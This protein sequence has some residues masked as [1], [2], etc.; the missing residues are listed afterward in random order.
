MDEAGTPIKSFSVIPRQFDKGKPTTELRADRIEATDGKFEIVVNRKEGKYV[1]AIE[2][3]GFRSTLTKAFD[4]TNAKEPI[5]VKLERAPPIQFK[6]VDEKGNAI[7]DAIVIVVPDGQFYS[8]GS[9]ER[10]NV[11]DWLQHRISDDQG[12]IQIPASSVPRMLFTYSKNCYGESTVL[13]KD[14]GATIEIRQLSD[15]H[16]EVTVDGKQAK[17]MTIYRPNSILVWI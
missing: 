1:L 17:A 2:A 13:P 4:R 11:P 7:K 3:E 5:E 10:T 12:Q 6:F 9:F 8:E 15:V 16:I 14:S